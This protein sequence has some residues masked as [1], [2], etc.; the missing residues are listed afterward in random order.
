MLRGSFSP[1]NIPDFRNVCMTNE[2]VYRNPLLG[3]TFSS[4]LKDI[5]VIYICQNNEFT[6]ALSV[7]V[8][9][10]SI[11]LHIILMKLQSFKNYRELQPRILSLCGQQLRSRSP[12]TVRG[13]QS[14]KKAMH[15]WGECGNS[16]WK[17]TTTLFL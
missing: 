14:T 2:Y 17:G 1:C 8:T 16:S 6:S 13:N 10:N 4:S 7:F 15:G 3:T 11:L 5:C 9:H 12:Y